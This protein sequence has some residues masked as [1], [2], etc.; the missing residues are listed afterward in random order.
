[1]SLGKSEMNSYW[2]PGPKLLG[3]TKNFPVEDLNWSDASDTI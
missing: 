2:P 1:M 3:F